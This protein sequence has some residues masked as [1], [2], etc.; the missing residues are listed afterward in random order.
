MRRNFAANWAAADRPLGA[1][2]GGLGAAAER[3]E[4]W[5]IV[6]ERPGRAGPSPPRRRSDHDYD[7][8]SAAAAA[9]VA[10]EHR[11]V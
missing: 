8:T 4:P 3:G 11:S 2:A 7:G 5:P 6:V 1:V 10:T 9:P